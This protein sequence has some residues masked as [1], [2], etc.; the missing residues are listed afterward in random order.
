LT[1]R[2][3]GPGSSSMSEKG[4]DEGESEAYLSFRPYCLE[5]SSFFKL[6]WDFDS[7]S[8][9]AFYEMFSNSTKERLASSNSVYRSSLLGGSSTSEGPNWPVS[10]KVGWLLSTSSS[11]V[12]F[13]VGGGGNG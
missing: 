8:R 6:L 13:A 9:A 10:S 7:I 2:C 12:T 11:G 1:K 5:V 4:F 3:F